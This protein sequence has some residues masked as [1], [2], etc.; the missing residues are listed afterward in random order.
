MS[1]YETFALTVLFGD[2]DT[3]SINLN[4]EKIMLEKNY[5][6]PGAYIVT[7]SLVNSQLSFSQNLYIIC[8]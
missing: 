7:G 3:R 6:Q 4:N 2:N 1:S 8:I 5:S